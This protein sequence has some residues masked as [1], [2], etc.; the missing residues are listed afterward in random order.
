MKKKKKKKVPRPICL[1][2]PQKLIFHQ[3]LIST[4]F[5]GLSNLQKLQQGKSTILR[6]T[7]DH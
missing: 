7:I 4:K 5:Q 1:D 3:L 2:Q 6:F